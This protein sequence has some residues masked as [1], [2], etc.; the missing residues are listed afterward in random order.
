MVDVRGPRGKGVRLAARASWALV[1]ALP[2]RGGTHELDLAN[3]VRATVAGFSCAPERVVNA[4]FAA[5]FLGAMVLSQG[6]RSHLVALL[7][8]LVLGVGFGF[9]L[10]AL[11]GAPIPG[12][13][14]ASRPATLLGMTVPPPSITLGLPTLFLGHLHSWSISRETP[15]SSKFVVA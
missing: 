9:H 1:E 7:G 8:V 11:F 15:M 5:T 3:R 10:A 4:P 6:L 12:E 13:C 14:P 2:I